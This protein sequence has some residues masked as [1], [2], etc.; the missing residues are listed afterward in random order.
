MCMYLTDLF[1]RKV[2]VWCENVEWVYVY[3]IL[4]RIVIC[5]GSNCKWEKNEIDMC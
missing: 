3:V 1:N 5:G 2:F 4:Y